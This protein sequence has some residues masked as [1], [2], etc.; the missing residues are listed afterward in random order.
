MKIKKR[1]AYVNLGP[2]AV[3][4]RRYIVTE[5]GKLFSNMSES[6]IANFS[7]LRPIKGHPD[8]KGYLKVKLY[9]KDGRKHTKRIH[10]LVL[11]SFTRKG[12]E[13]FF[14]DVPMN[15]QV[16]HINQNPSDNRLENLRWVTNEINASNRK[17]SYHSWSKSIKDEICEL[18]FGKKRGYKDIGAIKRLSAKNIREFL[19]GFIYEGYA[20]KWCK[21]HGYEYKIRSFSLPAKWDNGRIRR[22]RKTT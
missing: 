10:R 6:R 16:D 14:N 5:D 21:E 12:T 17:S 9:G 7:D 19:Y 2:A 20:E 8:E 22:C 15:Y 13:H 18:Y 1:W 3:L 4:G 11:E